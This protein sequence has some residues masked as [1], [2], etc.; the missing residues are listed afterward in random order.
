[1]EIPFLERQ[2]IEE[3]ANELCRAAFGSL[4]MEAVDLQSLVF[5]YLYEEQGL[6][7]YDDRRLGTEEE[8]EVL[9][10]TYPLKN[11]IHIDRRLAR[12]GHRGRYRFTVA[13]EIGHWVL[14][15]PLFLASDDIGED[16]RMITLQR[17]VRPAREESKN[18]YRPEEW[19]ANQFAIF[20]L[21]ND[22]ALGVA[23]RRRFGGPPLE[24][25]EDETSEFTERRQFSRHV[26]SAV[27]DEME[28]LADWFELSVEATAIALEERGYVGR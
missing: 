21:L 20:L 14:H 2:T 19:Q 26:A 12:E 16:A 17:D 5:D 24:P 15:R 27:V 9:G 4:P 11:E 28:S 6:A 23:F 10:V 22:E 13:H 18:S 3:R 7:F 25:P 8:Q 1:M